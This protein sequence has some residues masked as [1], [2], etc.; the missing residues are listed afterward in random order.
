MQVPVMWSPGHRAHA[1]LFYALEALNRGDLHQKVFD[2]I[3]QRRQQLLGR[4]DRETEQLHVQFARANGIDEKQFLQAYNSFMVNSSLQRAE[5]LTTAY[6]VQGVPLLVVNGKYTTDV[7]MAG[8]HEGLLA[9]L[10]DLA[11]SERR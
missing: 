3:H 5:R 6:R 9:L 8:G 10:D 7:G 1:R 2:S 4:S 11:A